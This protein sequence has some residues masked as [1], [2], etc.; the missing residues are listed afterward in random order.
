MKFFTVIVG[1]IVATSATNEIMN[2]YLTRYFF[3]TKPGLVIWFGF[4]LILAIIGIV[5]LNLF[6]DKWANSTE[7][8]RKDHA[9]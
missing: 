8:K 6:M 5:N 9:K 1:I 7:G 4:L 2:G 3:T